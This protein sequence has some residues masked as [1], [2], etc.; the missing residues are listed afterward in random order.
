MILI[1]CNSIFIP[2][3]VLINSKILYSVLEG[4][5]GLQ[6]YF[7][8]LYAHLYSLLPLYTFLYFGEGA[9]FCE[10]QVLTINILV[11]VKKIKEGKFGVKT[12]H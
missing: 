6:G 5:V 11:Q 4:N 1:L 10:D 3:F 7:V 12:N 2:V 8:K 9:I